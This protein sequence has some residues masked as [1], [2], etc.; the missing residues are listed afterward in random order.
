MSVMGIS[1]GDARIIGWTVTRGNVDYMTAN[2]FLG[3]ASDGACLLDLDGWVEGGIAQDIA[4]VVG[5]TYQVTFDVA[6]HLLASSA[7]LCVT[8]A[9]QSARFMV[10]NRSNGNDWSSIIWSNCVWSFVAT[11]TV[12]TVE[13]YSL[14]GGSCGPLLDHVLLCECANSIG[15]VAYYPFNG[16]A[17]DASGNNNHGTEYGGATYTNGHKGD[18][19]HLDGYDDYIDL[20]RFVIPTTQ[21]FTVA[22]WARQSSSQSGYREMI[23]QGQSGGS[24]FYIGHDPSYM[25][26]VGDVHQDTGISFPSD[27]QWHYYVVAVDRSNNT[28]RFYIDRDLLALWDALPISQSGSFTVFGRQFP[29]CCAEFFDGDIDEAYIYGRALSSNEVRQLY[30]LGS[31]QP[32]I[33]SIMPAQWLHDD[34]CDGGDAHSSSQR[35]GYFKCG[36]ERI[37]RYEC[38]RPYLVLSCVAQFGRKCLHRGGCR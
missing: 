5:E 3:A 38:G 16:N 27:G 8:A 1:P 10:P 25:V 30:E 14:G 24:G 37:R 22:L 26:R 17:N 33:D 23:S 7:S 15:L 28:T 4:S 19:I 36:R 2:P 35:D 20:N 6:A 13:F 29:S 9:G 21:S 34:E 18:A 31:S 32:V 12:T 11:S